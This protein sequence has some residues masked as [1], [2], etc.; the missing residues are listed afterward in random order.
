M[1]PPRRQGP[2]AGGRLGTV[3]AGER[4]ADEPYT[5]TVWQEL[6]QWPFCVKYFPNRAIAVS[7]ATVV[8][9]RAYFYRTVS[10]RVPAITGIAV[11]YIRSLSPP[12][13]PTYYWWLRLLPMATRFDWGGES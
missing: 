2:S 9:L 12:G 11:S 6:S 10:R 5:W 7:S 1:R 3:A 8:C 4:T 13:Q